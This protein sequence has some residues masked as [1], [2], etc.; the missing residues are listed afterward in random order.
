VGGQEKREERNER[1]MI[2]D[3]VIELSDPKKTVM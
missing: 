1:S 3:G 2:F